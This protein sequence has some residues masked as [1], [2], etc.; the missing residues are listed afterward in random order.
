[1]T[2][3]HTEYC[4]P[5]TEGE[6]PLAMLADGDEGER[7]LYRLAAIFKV[8]GEPTRLRIVKVLMQGERCVCDLA[9]AIGMEQSATS[10]QLRILRQAQVVSFRK[11]GKIARY[12]L[13]DEH[14][15]RILEQ[16]LAHVAHTH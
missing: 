9:E 7:N 11:E 15:L 3:L 16:G 14:V 2:K 13:M 4:E 12:Y 10:H 6:S 8:L 5:P 1:M